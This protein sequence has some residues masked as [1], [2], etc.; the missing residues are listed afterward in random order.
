M[1]KWYCTVLFRFGFLLT[2]LSIPIL[3]PL[4]SLVLPFSTM[5]QKQ[6]MAMTITVTQDFGFLTLEAVQWLRICVLETCVMSP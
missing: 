1:A 6:N 4:L 2:L 5:I 3:T